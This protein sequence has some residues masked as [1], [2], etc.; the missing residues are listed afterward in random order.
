MN[1]KT[2]YLFIDESG[3]LPD[4]KDNYIVICGVV[5]EKQKDAENIFSKTLKSLKSRKIKI[6]EVKFYH[7]GQNT[8]RQFLS[9]ISTSNFKIFTLIIDKKKRKIADNPENYSILLKNLIVDIISWNKKRASV[10]CFR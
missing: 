4:I 5:V 2:L 3:T 8:K 9:G 7:A 10:V 1:S 6:K